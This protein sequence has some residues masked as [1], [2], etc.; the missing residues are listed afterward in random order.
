MLSGNPTVKQ[1]AFLVTVLDYDKELNLP[2]NSND[3]KL[4]SSQSS[5]LKIKQ[6]LTTSGRNGQIHHPSL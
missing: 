2:G 3:S 5:C 6:T 4:L 1:K